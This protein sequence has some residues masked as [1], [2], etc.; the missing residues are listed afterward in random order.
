MY[1]VTTLPEALSSAAGNLQKIVENAQ[2]APFHQMFVS[3]LSAG[4]ESSVTT[5]ATDA[6][7]TG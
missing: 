1:L 4:G 2:A 5:K 6:V 7:A 3:T